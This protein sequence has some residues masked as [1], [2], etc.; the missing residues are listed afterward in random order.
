MKGCE[1]A[2]CA[3]KIDREPGG[4]AC[5]KGG[6]KGKIRHKLKE[7][8]P[9][10]PTFD[11]SHHWAGE[12]GNGLVVLKHNVKAD[13]FIFFL[14]CQSAS[15]CLNI[16]LHISKVSFICHCGTLFYINMLPQCWCCVTPTHYPPFLLMCSKASLLTT[17]YYIIELLITTMLAVF[18]VMN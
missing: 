10:L 2:L 5:K 18:Q 12:M 4:C 6:E 3:G 8:P 11:S 9:E 13:A 7:T 1:E 14:F 17:T 16:K 15:V